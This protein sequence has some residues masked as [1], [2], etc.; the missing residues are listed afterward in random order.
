MREFN[1]IE[2]SGGFYS[3]YLR[4][5]VE[6]ERSLTSK[7]EVKLQERPLIEFVSYCLNPNHFH[8]LVKQISGNGVVKFMQKLGTAYTMF[9]N[10]KCNRSGS[11]FQGTY[12]AIHVNDYGYLLKLLVYVNCN[13]EI[14]NLSK[15]EN[16]P[17]ASYLDSIGLRNGN[18]CNLEIIREE[19]GEPANFKAF[20]REIMTEIKE[21]KALKKYL[22]E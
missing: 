12:K 7:L 20:C 3:R 19:F 1:N 11:L 16:W 15:A 18:L 14:H 13:H 2:A 9:F 6:K 10:Q 22:L 8:F 5:K 17:W 21:N 4:E